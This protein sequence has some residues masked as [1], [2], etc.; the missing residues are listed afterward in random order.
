MSIERVI[1]KYP[2]RRLYDMEESRYITLSDVRRLVIGRIDFVITDKRDQA[3]ITREVLLQVIAE[4]EREGMEP[5]ISR[6]F[7]TE[8]IRSHGGQMHRAIG[9]HL[10]QSLRRFCGAA[11]SGA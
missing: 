4:Q 6:Y 8:V 11:E 9:S 1:K 10:E 2:N 7:L 3:D 5:V